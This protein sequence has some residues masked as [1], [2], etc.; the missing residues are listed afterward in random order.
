[1]LRSLIA[2]EGQ[3]KF[4]SFTSST[5]YDSV[6]TLLTILGSKKYDYFFLQVLSE[7]SPVL[8]TNLED[9]EKS[10]KVDWVFKVIMPPTYSIEEAPPPEKQGKFEMRKPSLLIPKPKLS[11]SREWITNLFSPN[12][13]RNP[14]C[15]TPETNSR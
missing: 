11:G 13:S 12:K 4:G 15:S 2:G 9:E 7:E 6:T 8:T 10:S 14:S 5:N 1:M 3:P